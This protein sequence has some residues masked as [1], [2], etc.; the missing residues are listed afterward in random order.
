MAEINNAGGTLTVKLGAEFVAAE[1]ESLR[2]ELGSLVAQGAANI[3]FDCGRV[4]KMDSRGLL[5]L[6]S[7]ANTT[8]ANGGKTTISNASADLA[9]LLRITGLDMRMEVLSA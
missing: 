2:A 6:V 7:A 1:A 3:V 9:D 8:A 5:L 4:S